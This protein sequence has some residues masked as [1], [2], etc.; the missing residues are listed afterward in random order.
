MQVLHTQCL[1]TWCQ[2]LFPYRQKQIATGTKQGHPYL[3]FMKRYQKL[4]CVCSPHPAVEPCSDASTS[5]SSLLVAPFLQLYR[6]TPP[7]TRNNR[8]FVQLNM[9]E[10]FI[11]LIEPLWLYVAVL[12]IHS[13][14][15]AAFPMDQFLPSQPS[16]KSSGKLSVGTIRRCCCKTFLANRNNSNSLVGVGGRLYCIK[17]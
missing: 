10:L 4:T 9:H 17:T 2:I 14:N 16:T 3:V 8:N 12:T 11:D 15:F 6:W 5:C 1:L 7:R 13:Y